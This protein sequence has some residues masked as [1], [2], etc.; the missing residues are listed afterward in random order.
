MAETPLRDAE[1]LM[2][3]VGESQ[4]VSTIV[5]DSAQEVHSNLTRV[6]RQI[7]RALALEVRRQHLRVYLY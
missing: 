2:S 4:Y 5:A 1:T 7:Q 6:V 3:L